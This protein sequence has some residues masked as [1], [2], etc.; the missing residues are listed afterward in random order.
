MQT[1]AV[2]GG[3]GR[4]GRLLVERL[5][6]Q[7]DRRIVVLGRNEPVAPPA[8]NIAFAR[9]RSPDDI[10]TAVAEATHVVN[11]ASLMLNDAIYA[12]R[13]A[14]LERAVLLGSTHIHTAFADDRARMLRTAE[15]HFRRSGVPG[16]ILHASMIYGGGDQNISR[17]ARLL[18]RSPL[19]PLPHGGRSLIQPIHFADVAVAIEAAL[20]APEACGEPMVIAG[21]Q[22]MTIRAMV[23][24]VAAGIGRRVGIVPVPASVIH[25]AAALTRMLPGLP[26]ILPAQV[27]RMFEDRAFDISDMRRRLNVEPRPFAV[28]RSILANWRP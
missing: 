6:R 15:E 25:A 24:A 28:D 13:S 7:P 5:A 22:P 2:I 16:V 23:E 4:V 8:G 11:C 21:P 20:Y 3:T 10:A 14:R 9:V 19:I 1:I 26:G 12:G 27:R 17:V 18:M